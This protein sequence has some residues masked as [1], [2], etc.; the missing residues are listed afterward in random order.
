M[1]PLNSL[2]GRPTIAGPNSPT[3]R[4]LSSLFEK[5]LNKFRT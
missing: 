3:R 5:K 2:N 4:R 1:E